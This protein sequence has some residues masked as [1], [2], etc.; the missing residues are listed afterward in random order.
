MHRSRVHYD[1]PGAI[2]DDVDVAERAAGH[3]LPF[4]RRM[5]PVQLGIFHDPKLRLDPEADVIARHWPT[6]TTS[7]S[8]A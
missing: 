4:A 7:G 2:R 3:S 1:K 8:A 5:Y 6:P